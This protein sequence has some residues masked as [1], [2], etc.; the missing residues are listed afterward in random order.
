MPKAYLSV[1]YYADVKH[2]AI[3]VDGK[4]TVTS[5]VSYT[6]IVSKF[7]Y[8]INRKTNKHGP[9]ETEINGY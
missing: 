5:Q 7:K 6:R 4:T 1:I 9:E 8:N 3:T 2:V